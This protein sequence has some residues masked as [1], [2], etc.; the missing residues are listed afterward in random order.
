[1]G[2]LPCWI[3]LFLIEGRNAACP[4][5]RQL[6][7]GECSSQDVISGVAVV[8]FYS[9]ST[10]FQDLRHLGGVFCQDPNLTFTCFT[11]RTLKASLEIPMD[12]NKSPC[13]QR[14]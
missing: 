11:P 9:G 6:Q 4:E 10:H 1:M 3:A 13:A 12:S 8:Q 7:L 5:G 14:P 2:W